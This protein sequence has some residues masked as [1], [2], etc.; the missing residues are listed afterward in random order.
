MLCGGGI[1]VR[2][3]SG[4]YF[5]LKPQI[6]LEVIGI[7]N[8][9]NSA[10]GIVFIIG[11]EKF[12]FRNGVPAVGEEGLGCGGKGQRTNDKEQHAKQHELLIWF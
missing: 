9:G 7:G 3:Q 8:A 6:E 2:I 10:I 5:Q 1:H 11:L 4:L 12:I